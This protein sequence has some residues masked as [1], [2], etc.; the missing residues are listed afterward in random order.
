[1][2]VYNVYAHVCVCAY[3]CVCLSAGH[4]CPAHIWKSEH[5]ISLFSLLFLAVSVE[6]LASTPPWSLLFLPV[7]SWKLCDDRARHHAQQNMGPGALHARP[8]AHLLSCLH[9]FVSLYL[10]LLFMDFMDLCR[11]YGLQSLNGGDACGQGVIRW[12]ISCYEQSESIYL[13]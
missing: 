2:C 4:T 8:Y 12:L 3:L 11:I 10:R 1:M 7:L 5:R 13:M 9:T 6:E